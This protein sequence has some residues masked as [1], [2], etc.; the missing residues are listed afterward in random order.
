MADSSNNNRPGARDWRRRVGVKK[1]MP[2]LA[3]DFDFKRDVKAPAPQK[4]PPKAPQ[5]APTASSGSRPA[6][7][8]VAKPVTRPAPMA[9]RRPKPASGAAAQADGGRQKPDPVK[10]KARSDAFSDRLRAQRE[11]AEALAKKR[12][13][14]TRNR[15]AG[16]TTANAG[17][18]FSFA[19]EE[20]KAATKET[21][22]AAPMTPPVRPA[23]A[24]AAPPRPLASPPV[25]NE[26]ATE[27][28]VQPP[29]SVNGTNEME[30]GSAP[31]PTPASAPRTAAYRSALGNGA[32]K[33]YQ[34]S[35]AYR[36]SHG[37]ADLG[38][39]AEA[40]TRQQPEAATPAAYERYSEDGAEDFTAQRPA[41]TPPGRGEYPAPQGRGGRYADDGF[42]DEDPRAARQAP[43]RRAG[44]ADYSAAYND[45]DDAF[46]Y[47]EEPRS[48][49]G[50]WIFIVLMLIVVAAIAA[51][52]YWFINNGTKI[53]A[54]SNGT[55]VPTVS[56]PQAPVKTAPKPVDTTTPTA[57]V[58]RKKI[59]DRIL[60]D[61][62][63]EPEKLAP[64]E[65]APKAVP[66]TAQPV[67]PP[68][69]QQ[70][71]GQAPIGVEPLPLPLPPPPTVPGEQGAVSQK[72]HKVASAPPVPNTSGKTG[73]TTISPAS[74][75][76]NT[77]SVQAGGQVAPLPL[78]P[79]GSGDQAA[80]NSQTP[81][82]TQTGN[83]EAS[84]E[85]N[86]APP[87]PRSK[88]NSIIARARR[89]A[90]QRRLAALTSSASRTPA[91]PRQV[92]PPPQALTQGS[93][94]VQISPG[95]TAGAQNFN[96]SAPAVRQPVVP[97]P[98]QTKIAS[99]P[100]PRQQAPVAPTTVGGGYV[101]QMS[102]FRNRNAASAE[103][104]R[105]ISRHAGVLRGLSPEIQEA[106]LG[107]GGKFYKLRLG[108]VASRSQ[109][110]RMCNSL[111]A[112]GEKDCLVRRR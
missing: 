8:P 107:A 68:A 86:V 10:E 41:Y 36:Q 15:L 88:P 17:P 106:N 62:T 67:Q 101:L 2:K 95:T 46:E 49:S 60:G 4:A 80:T 52:A 29:E 92:L 70:P 104:R 56:A 35:D 66:P 53:G 75:P 57:P 13:D 27:R 58:K 82:A 84:P 31:A 43:P 94:P 34:P 38:R 37:Y 111:I 73:Q 96:S 97:Q 3:D 89:L 109:A 110:A 98:P 61:Q 45:Y 76:Q 85:T 39:P 28:R 1:E 50:L 22:P 63:L 24:R 32:P 64:S 90:E 69:G 42:Y 11:A 7:K 99:L 108:S 12:A 54:S 93:G 74:A 14:E 16:A 18:R 79:V 25:A 105:L 6:P 102:S 78:P 21:Q 59:Y 20:I 112:A 19:E 100:Q 48:R 77:S 47:G 26:P 5:P 9:P 33:P 83:V 71:A 87:V 30:A 44:A 65:E 51:G 72:T 103:Y 40:A 23:P 55:G 91:A 81:T